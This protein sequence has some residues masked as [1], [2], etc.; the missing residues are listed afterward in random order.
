MTGPAGPRRSRLPVL[1]GILVALL[2]ISGL[3]LVGGQPLAGLLVLAVATLLN[4]RLLALRRRL[5]RRGTEPGGR[6][7]RPGPAS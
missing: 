6:P 3:L 1:H 7:P 5:D 4:V 2:L